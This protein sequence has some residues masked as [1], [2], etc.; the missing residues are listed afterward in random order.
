MGTKATKTS[1]RRRSRRSETTPAA[2]PAR[3]RYPRWLKVVLG[4]LLVLGGWAAYRNIQVYQLRELAI[5]AQEARQAGHWGDVEAITRRWVKRDPQAAV[6]WL[7][8]AEAAQQRGA[9]ERAAGY[10]DQLPDED[11]RTPTAMLELATMNFGPLNR[12]VRGE[13]A[14]QR[15]IALDPMHAEARRRLV[16]FYGITLQRTKMAEEAREAIER[17]CD[18][19]ETYVYLMGTDWLTFTNAHE[20]NEKWLRSGTNLETHFVAHVVHWAGAKGLDEQP[21]FVE[22]VDAHAVALAEHERHLRACFEQYPDNPE[23][24]AFFLKKKSTEADVQ[25]VA[26][27]L[28]RVPATAAN[29]G[30]FWHYK[31]WLHAAREELEAAEAAYRRALEVNPYDWRSQLQL[32]E[33][34]RKQQR[35]DEVESL[36]ALSMEGKELRKTV[37]QLP[38]VQAVPIAVM[39]QMRGY[40]ERVQDHRVAEQ[41]ALRITQMRSSG[42]APGTSEAWWTASSAAAAEK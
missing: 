35:F 29:D 37:L 26:E 5:E 39:E 12:P 25:G 23:L 6:A 14:L 16:F 11:W 28:A 24:L 20:Y 30:R 36:V 21:E 31:G 42:A 2:A 40:A 27:L 22:D 9:V 3:R 8:A 32:A 34:L 18:V 7:M 33:V 19:P 10:L 17:G 15:A 1:P 38:D 4:V 41:L 13:A